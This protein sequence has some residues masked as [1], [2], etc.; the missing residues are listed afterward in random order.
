[1]ADLGG[2]QKPRNQKRKNGKRQNRHYRRGPAGLTA[3]IYAARANLAPVIY[4]G[5]QA[6]G[7]LMLTTEVE[8]FPGFPGGV[9]GPELM[10]NIREQ[11]MNFGA[12]IIDE[13]VEV[14]DF[15]VGERH[16][17]S[18]DS[19]EVRALSVIVATG[20]SAKWLGVPGEARL[21]GRG[22]STCA[23]CD[24]AFFRDKNIVVVGGGDSA[25]EEAI[26][27]TRFGKT[28][29]VVHR[30]KDFRAS[31]VILERAKKNPKITFMTGWQTEEIIGEEKVEAIRLH[32]TD[33]DGALEVRTDGVFLAIGHT[34]N[35]AI[36]H[37]HLELDGAG[38]IV[39]DDGVRTSKSG[40]FV[41][42][43][44]FDVRYRQ[45]ITAAASGCK[46]A[47]EAE[48]FIDHVEVESLVHN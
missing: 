27:L 28:V 34:P 40:V 20:A 10:A 37:S 38:Y 47:L 33:S 43:D 31:K 26:F 15:N 32:S 30:S 5:Y 9:M 7:Q 6:G 39:S 23:T 22:V 21:R 14:V 17:V 12:R 3:A 11:A 48:K 41:A 42:G 1:V 16:M 29:T 45:A 46:A 35:T 44:V 18:S 8:N 4:A 36:F 13:D 2:R 25:M 19:R 24:G